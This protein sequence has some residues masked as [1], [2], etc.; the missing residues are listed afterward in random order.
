MLSRKDIIERV[1]YCTLR[2]KTFISEK[3]REKATVPLVKVV[4]VKV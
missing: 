1:Y 4:L 2:K 3:P